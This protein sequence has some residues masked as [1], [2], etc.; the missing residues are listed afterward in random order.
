MLIDLVTLNDE[1]K[2]LESKH[3][4]S[5]KS[6]REIVEMRSNTSK[7]YK[8][9]EC[10]QPVRVKAGPAIE[11]HFYHPSTS[12]PC[13]LQPDST[14]GKASIYIGEQR[15]H[16]EAKNSLALFFMKEGF[17]VRVE[18]TIRGKSSYKRPDIYIK[19]IKLAIEVQYSWIGIDDLIERT[20]FYKENDHK[21]L[22]VFIH[23]KNSKSAQLLTD[24]LY[25]L[26]SREQVFLFNKEQIKQCKEDKTLNLICEYTT[27]DNKTEQRTINYDDLI[28]D[29]ETPYVKN[30]NG[31]S[32]VLLGLRHSA[33][34]SPSYSAFCEKMEQLITATK[35][36]SLSKKQKDSI[37]R[38]LKFN[39]TK[40]ID[41][42]SQ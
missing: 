32:D 23:K 3:I 1:E 11:T 27:Y 10:D 21:V 7:I 31:R 37:T 2:P 26:D 20:N 29:E 16:I 24:A 36:I 15:Q 14:Q 4:F 40:H 33:I 17:D 39:G 38:T 30:K 34:K 13:P 22:W 18:K 5:K 6:D 41:L 19:G 12:K 8:C 9:F 35:G 25:A 28:F 42:T